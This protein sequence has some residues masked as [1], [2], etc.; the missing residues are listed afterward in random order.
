MSDRIDS[1]ALPAILQ[2]IVQDDYEVYQTFFQSASGT[3][4]YANS[5]TYITQACRGLGLG[6]KYLD[7]DRLFSVGRHNGHYVVVNPLGVVDDRL[8]TVLATLHEL[9]GKPVFVKKASAAHTAA[10]ERIGCIPARPGG[11][12]WDDAAYADDDTYPELIVDLEVSLGYSQRPRE[13]YRL[14]RAVRN[15]AG[16]E[17]GASTRAGYRQFRRSVRRG[18]AAAIACEVVAYRPSMLAAVQQLVEE[19]FGG[20]RPEAPRVY[21]NLLTSLR[22]GIREGTEFCF[23]VQGGDG[24]DGVIF[25]ERLDA[26]SAAVYARLIRR[27]CA[28]LPEYAMA[29]ALARLRQEGI[30]RVN[31]GGSETSGLH[32]FKKKLAPIEER[33]LPLLVYGY[34]GGC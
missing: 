20:E 1:A 26:C 13:W 22:R 18:A 17:D 4:V 23:A 15:G 32:V 10:L 5:W 29:Q 31:L 12:L 33:A 28:G 9:S 2:P 8:E 21:D 11:Y 16:V 30:R 25:A 3:A 19:Y 24:V 14:Y 6:W 34:R 27:T 7:G